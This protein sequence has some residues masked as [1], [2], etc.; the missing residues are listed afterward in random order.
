[1]ESQRNGAECKEGLPKAGC[2]RKKGSLQR[3]VK[4]AS[5]SLMDSMMSDMLGY[6]MLTLLLPC[7]RFS[8]GPIVQG[9]LGYFI[10]ELDLEISV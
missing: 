8:V 6:S 10:I 7:S 2:G 5:L 4:E 3:G 1:M 9:A